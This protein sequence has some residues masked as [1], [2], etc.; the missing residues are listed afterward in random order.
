MTVLRL[1]AVLTLAYSTRILRLPVHGWTP[2]R[3]RD[4]VGPVTR[5]SYW[6]DLKE[7]RRALP[8]LM[9]DTLQRLPRTIPPVLAWFRRVRS[10]SARTGVGDRFVILMLGV[11][12]ARVKV[13]EVRAD[14]FRLG[15]LRQHSESGWIDFQYRPLGEGRYRLRVV[16]QVRASS[17][18][19]RVA[20]LCGVGILQ[21]LTW[22]AGLR[23]VLRRSGGQKVGHGTTTVEWP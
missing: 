21:R 10:T 8:E 11:R 17:W 18:F 7:P 22:E 13:T 5:R 2:T 20:Y 12:R 6:V 9:D 16:S 15:T 1:A 3:E 14:G 19:D 4:G 23:R